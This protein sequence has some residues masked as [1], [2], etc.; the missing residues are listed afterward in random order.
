M[1]RAEDRL[2]GIPE[3]DKK[4]IV[5]KWQASEKA[6]ENVDKIEDRRSEIK[7]EIESLNKEYLNLSDQWNQA[8][9]EA[10]KITNDAVSLENKHKRIRDSIREKGNG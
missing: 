1:G 2:Q 10:H 4:A 3:A 7:Y 9:P 5:S 8:I 6:W